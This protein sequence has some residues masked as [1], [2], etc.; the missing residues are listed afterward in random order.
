MSFKTLESQDFLVSA[1]SI[2]APCW[3]N[4]SP[5][6]TTMYTSSTQ[7]TGTSGQYFLNIY[8]TDPNTD[9]TAEVQFNI[10]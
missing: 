1:D 4:Y 3:T 7:V 2:T 5:T 6:L 10:A 8:N 9:T